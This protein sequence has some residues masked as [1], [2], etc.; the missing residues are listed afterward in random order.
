MFQ[1]A[2]AP[3]PRG[4]GCGTSGRPLSQAGGC[5][6]RMCD[7]ANLFHSGCCSG[8]VRRV[9][10]IF[11]THRVFCFVDLGDDGG[12]GH[13]RHPV[14]GVADLNPF[15]VVYVLYRLFDVGIPWNSDEPLHSHPF[16]LL[17]RLSGTK[18]LCRPVW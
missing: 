6:W 7:V 8:S 4:R 1:I 18:S 9:R 3:V 13:L 15:R 2:D 17:H 12:F 10:L 5:W 14:G 11:Q 16:Q